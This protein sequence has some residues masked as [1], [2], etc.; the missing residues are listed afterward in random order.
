MQANSR[1][2]WLPPI[3][4]VQ[5][6]RGYEPVTTIPNAP[7]FFK[8]CSPCAGSSDPSSTCGSIYN[9]TNADYLLGIGIIDQ[10][11]LIQ[12]DIDRMMSSSEIG[13]IERLAA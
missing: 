5:K 7:D 12:I 3:L 2:L 9:T 8:G 6:I 1:Q 13:L 10:R 4:Q 11:M